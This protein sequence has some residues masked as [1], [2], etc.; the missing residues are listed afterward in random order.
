MIIKVTIPD[1]P[2][3]N[4]FFFFLVHINFIQSVSKK[5]KK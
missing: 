3:Y 4:N 1:I 2:K 5:K